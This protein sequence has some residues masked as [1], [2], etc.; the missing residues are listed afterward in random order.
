L[1]AFL[2]CS[3]HWVAFVIGGRMDS[4]WELPGFGVKMIPENGNGT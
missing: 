2:V 4:D 3:N 1:Q